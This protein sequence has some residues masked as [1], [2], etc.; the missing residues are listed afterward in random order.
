MKEYEIN[1]LRDKNTYLEEEVHHKN[2]EI[3]N[4]NK[5]LQ[6]K[7][8]KIEVDLASRRD[9]PSTPPPMAAVSSFSFEQDY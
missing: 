6:E 9:Q 4:N 2:E 7:L 3:F 8:N 5:F 1:G